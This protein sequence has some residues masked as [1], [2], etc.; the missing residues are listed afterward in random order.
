ML[1]K[2]A[3]HDKHNPAYG[4]V[5]QKN[6][7]KAACEAFIDIDKGDQPAIRRQ[8]PF[9]IAATPLV[10]G[11]STKW[12]ELINGSMP[13][14][15]IS[16]GHNR[17]DGLR[18]LCVKGDEENR[19]V[20]NSSLDDYGMIYE[21]EAHC[22]Y[23]SVEKNN[24]NESDYVLTYEIK[25]T[26]VYKRQWPTIKLSE[27]ISE[28]M[29]S[30]VDN[31]CNLNSTDFK[32]VT[33]VSENIRM[34]PY[35]AFNSLLKRIDKTVHSLKDIPDHDLV[36]VGVDR[37]QN[38]LLT[39]ASALSLR[40]EDIGLIKYTS[41]CGTGANTTDVTKMDKK[42]I[43]ANTIQDVE[44]SYVM[45]LARL[46]SSPH[47]K[48]LVKDKFLEK[49]NYK[50]AVKSAQNLL[51]KSG[52]RHKKTDLAKGGNEATKAH[53][54]NSL[55]DD[56]NSEYRRNLNSLRELKKILDK[57]YSFLLAKGKK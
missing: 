28:G 21:G 36:N 8:C 30:I 42:M 47:T 32:S 31:F 50:E 33:G 1:C 29:E 4:E 56:S 45:V 54:V 3:T 15:P 17:Y 22:R 25:P 11:F 18:Y 41:T 40:R 52:G 20:S 13:E 34:H 24:S 37:L 51:S 16:V 19:G 55:F 2:I 57:T 44:N 27:K 7:G 48:S 46:K 12:S 53:S 5:I 23:R 49:Y 39:V 43:L 6:N 14:N 38:D 35:R 10:D 26:T 9:F